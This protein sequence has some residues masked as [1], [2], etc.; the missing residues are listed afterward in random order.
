MF[1]TEVARHS[2]PGG[3]ELS[4]ERVTC[5]SCTLCYILHIPW[6]WTW[7]AQMICWN[8]NLC[9]SINYAS[10]ANSWNKMN[11][12]LME[13]CLGCI[14]YRSLKRCTLQNE[15]RRKSR[16]RDRHTTALGFNKNPGLLKALLYSDSNIDSAVTD[17]LVGEGSKLGDRRAQ[18]PRTGYWM[19]EWRGA[20][21]VTSTLNVMHSAPEVSR[22]SLAP[23]LQSSD[24]TWT[25]LEPMF[26]GLRALPSPP[27]R[28]ALH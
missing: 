28:V 19:S 20:E 10:H 13:R 25:Y 26:V 17:V 23:G 1:S 8:P 4:S 22:V 12:C 15:R 3:A 18:A 24:P 6:H 9:G 2:P 11:P 21:V 5:V 14:E 27:A 7:I 16:A